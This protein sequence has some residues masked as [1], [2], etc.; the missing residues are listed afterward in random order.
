MGIHGAFY[1]DIRE[2]YEDRC[3]D[4]KCSQVNHN[5]IV[6]DE[7]FDVLRNEHYINV[8]SNGMLEGT[9]DSTQALSEDQLILLPFR[10]YGYTL[11]HRYW[12]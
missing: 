4:Q 3:I 9:R 11:R 7:L 6:D 10:L 12:G 5:C 2:L 8:E 1:S